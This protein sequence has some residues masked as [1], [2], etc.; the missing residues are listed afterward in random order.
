[1]RA[2]A[3][4]QL[5]I[6]DVAGPVVAV[7]PHP[8][9]E[10]LGCGGL[11]A[12]LADAR[13]PV[14]VIL[15]TDGSASHPASRHWPPARLAALRREEMRESLA[16][17]GLERAPLADLALPDGAVPGPGDPGFALA[18]QTIAE[19]LDASLARTLVAP[20]RRDAHADHRAC[21]GLVREAL[22]RRR[23]R[24]AIRVFEYAVWDERA[25]AEDRPLS[26]EAIEWTLDIAAARQR[27][28]GAIAAH[29]SQCGLVVEDDPGGFVLPE[30]MRERAAGPVERYWEV[31]TEQAVRAP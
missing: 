21:H 26:G 8:D 12:L 10:A 4:R 29:R 23:R 30:A 3:L 22:V 28:A 5:L 17:L 15:V 7:V 11:L 24:C 18:A 25:A 20:W 27:K 16:R 31:V 19:T 6:A 14:D 9:D 1:M 13:V 2:V